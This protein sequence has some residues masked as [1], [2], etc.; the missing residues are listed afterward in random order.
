MNQ[1]N[2]NLRVIRRQKAI[3]RKMLECEPTHEEKT[4]LENPHR[5]L[6]SKSTNSDITFHSAGNNSRLFFP[7]TEHFKRHQRLV[8]K[9]KDLF[10]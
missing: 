4:Y 8:L 9:K 5:Y 3:Y 1:L 10:L 2:E 7:P 6:N